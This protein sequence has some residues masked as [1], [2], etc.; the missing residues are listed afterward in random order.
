MKLLYNN[1]YWEDILGHSATKL[2]LDKRLHLIFSLVIFLQISVAKLLYFI[3]TSAVDEVKTRSS[4]FM[5]YT[6]SAGTED[7]K[8]PP[9]MVFRAWLD[10][11]PDAREHMHNMITPFVQGIVEKESEKMI[12]DVELK[13]KM[14]TLTLKGIQ[15]LLQPQRV[16][17]KYLEHAPFTWKLLHTFA[18]TPN[19]YR[20][21]RTRNMPANSASDEEHDEIADDWDDDPN[22]ADDEPMKMWDS[23]QTPQGFTRNP[24][25]VSPN[26]I[27]LKIK[28]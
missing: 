7:T 2:T 18:T 19:E 4:R 12:R 8:F 28:N 27:H 22:F 26:P 17:E 1:A 13:V 3:F 15:E 14:K 5:G 20:K 9:G 6:P 21:Q 24:V 23:M 10:N 16:M 25:L 11:F